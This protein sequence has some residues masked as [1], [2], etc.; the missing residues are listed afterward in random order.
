MRWKMTIVAT[1]FSTGRFTSAWKIMKNKFKTKQ[2]T[3][4]KQI[5]HKWLRIRGN[6][7]S[8]HE[9]CKTMPYFKLTTESHL[10]NF[11]KKT[12]Q[13][14]EKYFKVHKECTTALWY[15]KIIIL[16]NTWNIFLKYIYFFILFF[17]FTNFIFP[18]H[19][20]KSCWRSLTR[21]KSFSFLNECFFLNSLFKF[22]SSLYFLFSKF[23]PSFICPPLCQ[24]LF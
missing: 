15:M 20:S 17:Q 14:T 4:N 13:K 5:K 9:S 12:H 19:H 22:T 21:P 18:I 8:A 3:S 10:E 7:C 24:V 11:W 16:E 23:L 1:I 2:N 6:Y